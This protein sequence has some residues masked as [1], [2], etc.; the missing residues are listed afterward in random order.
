[1]SCA[2]PRPVRAPADA[3]RTSRTARES[4]RLTAVSARACCGAPP[5]LR[6]EGVREVKFCRGQQIMLEKGQLTPE[7]VQANFAA[8]ARKIA[9]WLDKPV[10]AYAQE[11]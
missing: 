4:R 7:E 8:E 1:M 11:K 2:R 3:R 6:R 9:Q 5:A 10:P